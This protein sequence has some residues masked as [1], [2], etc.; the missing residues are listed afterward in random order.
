MI[1]RRSKKEIDLLESSNELY[2]CP[3]CD[4]HG[5]VDEFAYE[6]PACGAHVDDEQY[7]INTEYINDIVEDRDA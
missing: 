1:R 7:D 3:S 2:V 5:H 4:Y 6:C